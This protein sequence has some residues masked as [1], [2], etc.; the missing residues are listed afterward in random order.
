[1]SV[2]FQRVEIALNKLV[3]WEGNVRKTDPETG[4]Y[5]LAASIE[6]HGLMNALTVREAGRGKFAVVAGQRRLKALRMLAEGKIIPKSAAIA[7]HLIKGEGDPSELSLA[8]NVVRVAMHPADQFEAWRDLIDKGSSPGEVAA[9]FGVAESTVRKRMVLA[10]VSPVVFDAYRAG[11]IEL[12]ALQAFTVTDDHAR[13]ETVWQGL[14]GWQKSDAGTIRKALTEGDVPTGDRRVKFVGLD[15]YEAAGGT[16]RRDLFASEDG[17]YCRDVPLLD[18][19]AREKLQ[20]MAADLMKEEGWK[21]TEGRL[22]FG[23]DE[24]K[25]FDRAA[26][27]P[28]DEALQAEQE[29]LQEEADDLMEA[30]DESGVD[31]LNAV[32]TR[33]AEIEDMQ[34]VWS[35]EVKA[36]AGAV[37][38]LSCGGAAGIERGLIREGD[39]PDA[40]AGDPDGVESSDEAGSEDAAPALPASLIED[41]TAH[42]TAALRIELARSPEIALALTV[43]AMAGCAFY[44][45]GERVLKAWM[46]VRSLERSMQGY[47]SCAAVQALDAERSRVRDL[48]PGCQDDLWSWCLTADR[49]ALLDVLAVATAYGLDAVVT[50]P[51]QNRSGQ[52]GGVRLAEALK[53]DMAGWY[54]PTASGYF[55]RISKASILSD[56]EAAKGVPLPRHGPK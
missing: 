34:A 37:V 43:H 49:D 2:N 10:R 16:V 24:Q 14:N 47:D 27:L 29:A 6:A 33:L 50:K 9:R 26:P 23:W 17:G 36:C 28:M 21:W 55:G 3:P 8:E 5:E 40:G 42:K 56:L 1:M 7:C 19:L 54:Q 45:G 25:R 15:A 39:L 41:L 53:L 38:Y 44:R 30:E 52:D 11:E 48:L 46:T 12:E 51:D 20:G 32:E 18:R 13:Q 22:S 4:L 31:R 35:G